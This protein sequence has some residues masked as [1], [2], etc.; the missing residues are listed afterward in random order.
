MKEVNTEGQKSLTE[1][2]GIQSKSNR[3]IMKLDI[4]FLA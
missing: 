1:E 3:R 4:Q 2:S